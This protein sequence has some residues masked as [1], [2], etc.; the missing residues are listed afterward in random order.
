MV[1]ES[2]G[3]WIGE[4]INRTSAT[5]DALLRRI[6]DLEGTEH[7]ILIN[8]NSAQRRSQSWIV[9]EGQ[10]FV[11]GDNRDMSQDSRAWG[12]VPEENLVG[13]ASRIW[14]H[15]DCASRRCVVF[16][17]IGDKID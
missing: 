13:R 16:D 7:E 11:M 17:R 4:G 14:M 6:E 15:W 12:F 8:A 9:P 2:D 10:Y 5:R 3:L 1:Q